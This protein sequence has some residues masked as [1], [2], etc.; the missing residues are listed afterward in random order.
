MSD[1]KPVGAR[2]AVTVKQFDAEQRNTVFQVRTSER[3]Q[4][5]FFAVLRVASAAVDTVHVANVTVL[6]GVQGTALALV[7]LAA[8]VQRGY[9]NTFAMCF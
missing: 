9:R 2:Y 3:F 4:N 6:S 1:H 8:V 7:C 5:S